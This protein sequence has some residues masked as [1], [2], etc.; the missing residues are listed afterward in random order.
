MYLI[1]NL[2]RLLEEFVKHRENIGIK[3]HNTPDD[4]DNRTHDINL[5]YSGRR[6]PEEWLVC[7]KNLPRTLIPKTLVQ[8]LSGTPLLNAYK[9]GLTSRLVKY[10]A[11]QLINTDDTHTRN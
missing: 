1:I 7:K 9:V 8:D 3:Y 5:P 6:S 11:N 2:E 10:H 4:N